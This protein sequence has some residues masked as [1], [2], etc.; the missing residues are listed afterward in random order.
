MRT[1][2]TRGIAAVGV[3]AL[4]LTAITAC[5][6]TGEDAGNGEVYGTLQILVSSSSGSDAAFAKVNEA[7]MKKYPDVK[8]EF[9]AVPNENFN[10]TRSSRL[11]AGNV[12]VTL[13][14]PRDVPA[15]AEGVSASDD[16]VAADA[17][18]FVDLTDQ[19][20]MKNFTPTVL[21]ATAYNGKQYT[22][23]TGLSYYSGVYYN[24]KIFDDL[25]LEIPTTWSEFESVAAALQKDGVT[26][27]GIGGK[28]SWPAGLA[29]L[30][31]VQGLYPTAEDKNAL[32][33]GLWDNSLSL[34]DGTQLQVLERVK[35][36]YDMAQKNFAG[37]GYDAIPSGFA[38]GD[39]AM[40]I[41]GTWN[42][43]TIDAA[44]GDAFE[45]G[46]FPLPASDD[47]ADNATLAGK[48]ELRL[49]A[50]SNAPN[51]AAALA[52]L[53]FFSSPD[54]YADFVA[55]TGF[56]PAQPNITASDFLTGIADYT[57]TFSPAWDT[58]WVSNQDAGPAA[59]FPFNYPAIAPLGT[60]TVPQ[61]AQ[62][63]QS[64]W[65]AAF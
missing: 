23:P 18:L 26:P 19:P 9:S 13:A 59:V 31:A 6:S 49:A 57:A 35:S 61:A 64:A 32:A 34:T 40:T 1:H 20:F 47:A 58:I 4:A 21:E 52:Y 3:A 65:S 14:Q 41:D 48:V 25:G 39:F 42:Q 17:G 8:V 55:T 46:Y 63:A 53:D 51:K 11:T 45:Y 33:T 15:F 56:A 28:D 29:M 24:K 43:T 30:A 37:V 54:T 50:A 44:V 10:S 2:I 38:N 27:L 62:E 12:D 60:M 7:F 22:V 5:S 16:N 36:L